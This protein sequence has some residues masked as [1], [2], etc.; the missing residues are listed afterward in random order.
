MY[1]IYHACTI[2]N[3]SRQQSSH[4]ITPRSIVPPADRC[5]F[6]G[7]PVPH[8]INAVF[9]NAHTVRGLRRLM[10]TSAINQNGFFCGSSPG[11]SIYY[12]RSA[13]HVNV[14]FKTMEKCSNFLNSLMELEHANR[15][16]VVLAYTTR[17]TQDY[18]E[19]YWSIDYMF[20]LRHYQ[21]GQGDP[22]VMEVSRTSRT[23]Q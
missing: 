22:P 4:L 5:G 11:G 21:V 8:I 14:R 20:N 1:V 15:G 13:L 19:E 3:N 10:F 12:R 18:P 23:P 9:S 7:Y 17:E 16:N 6:I 2:K